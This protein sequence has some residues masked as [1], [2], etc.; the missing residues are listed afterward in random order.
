MKLKK[1]SREL[2]F[3]T[4]GKGQSIFFII[5]ISPLPGFD[6]YY[7]TKLKYI[8]VSINTTIFGPTLGYRE[9]LPLRDKW[10][11]FVSTKVMIIFK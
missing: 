2:D 6:Y 3:T 8:A 5:F 4:N 10:E 9:G 7:G 11:E 1:E